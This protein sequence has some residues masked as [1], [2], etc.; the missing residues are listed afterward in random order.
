MDHNLSDTISLLS[1]TPSTL[2][3]LLRNL[4]ETWT[5]SNEGGDTWTTLEVLGHLIDA[6]RTNWIPRA[7]SIL[8]FGET[9]PFPPFDR[10]GHLRGSQGKSLPQLLDEFA[11]TR[12]A[13]LEEL[14]SWHLQP[15]QL[16]LRGHHPAFG[17]VT[18]SQLL[19]TWAT[20]DLT[21][22]HQISRILAHQYQQAVG[23][24]SQ[25]L[26]VLHCTAHSS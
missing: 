16:N 8:Q 24:W 25:Y 9:Q 5:R 2:D 18:L 6:D 22:L 23:P 7:K 19:A 3:A 17:S 12:T 11:L 10:G 13:S 15:D 21:H 26:G 1:H 20:H 14:R 4:P